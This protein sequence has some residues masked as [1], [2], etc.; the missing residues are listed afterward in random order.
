MRFRGHRS[1]GLQFGSVPVRGSHHLALKAILPVHQIGNPADLNSILMTANRYNLPV[2]EDAACAVGSQ[3]FR[4]GRWQQIG[5]PHGRIACFSFHPR[6]VITTGE[7]G[8]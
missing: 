1:A 2:V 4:N 5:Q 7:E 3:I 8:C 6:K